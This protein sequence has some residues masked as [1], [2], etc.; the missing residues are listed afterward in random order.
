MKIEKVALSKVKANPNNPRFFYNFA[1]WLTASDT[2]RK[3]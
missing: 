2:K 1:A 3:Q